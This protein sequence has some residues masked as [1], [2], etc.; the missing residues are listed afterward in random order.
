MLDNYKQIR[1]VKEIKPD[2]L[3]WTAIGAR[4]K[5]FRESVQL[6]HLEAGQTLN[7]QECA[8][9]A[10]ENGS[11][12]RASVNIIWEIS[13]AWNLSLNWLLNGIGSFYEEDPVELLPETLLVQKGAG[14]RRSFNRVQAEEGRYTDE[15][16]EFVTAIDKFKRINDIRFPTWTQTY[17]VILALGYRK[18]A[19]ARIAPLGYIIEHQKQS[20]NQKHYART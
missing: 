16:L 13:N 14:I 4:F 17:E 19:P 7:M 9:R 8:L 11:Y 2:N 6:G 10:F 15:V 20:E 1:Y 12:K 18:S 5:F 3:D